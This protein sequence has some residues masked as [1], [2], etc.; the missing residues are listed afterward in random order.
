MHRAPTR[1]AHGG[2]GDRCVLPQMNYQSIMLSHDS[3]S[4]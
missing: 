4:Y 3:I 2:V 1:D